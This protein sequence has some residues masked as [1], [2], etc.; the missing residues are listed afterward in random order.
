MMKTVKTFCLVALFAFNSKQSVERSSMAYSS[1]HPGVNGRPQRVQQQRAI[2]NSGFTTA[3]PRPDSVNGQSRVRP[4]HHPRQGN[5]TSD[6]ISDIASASITIDAGQSSTI[7][8]DL[9]SPSVDE[10]N[11]SITGASGGVGGDDP[12]CTAKDFAHFL[13]DGED[14]IP[15]GLKEVARRVMEVEA[16]LRVKMV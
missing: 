16:R 7:A 10:S 11:P 14:N 4:Q 8:S 3:T 9:P 5:N 13:E 2:S 12:D 1:S 6:F 15:R